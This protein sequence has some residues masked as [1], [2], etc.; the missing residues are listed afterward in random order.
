MVEVHRSRGQI[1]SMRHDLHMV[2]G[3]DGDSDNLGLIPGHV[4]AQTQTRASPEHR[5]LVLV[6]SSHRFEGRGRGLGRGGVL[7]GGLGGGGLGLE[8]SFG[9]ELIG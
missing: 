4:L 7:Y 8:P 3:Q 5:V 2:L 6:D 1:W 9:E